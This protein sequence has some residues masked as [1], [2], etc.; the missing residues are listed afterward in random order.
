[1]GAYET[2]MKLKFNVSEVFTSIQGEGSRAGFPSVFIRLQGCELRCKW[3]DTP[4]ALDLKERATMLS[5]EDLLNKIYS[6]GIKFVTITGGEPLNQKAILPF[7]SFLCDKDYTVVLETNGHLDIAEVDRRVVKVMD[8]KCPGSGME[9]FNNY[10]N[11]EA[12]EQKDEIK[13][14][15]L[16]RNDYEWAKAKIKEYDLNKK[17]GTILFS[18]VWGKLEPK[19]L[20]EWILKDALPVRLNLQIHKYIWGP[21][22][23]G[24]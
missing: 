4:Y 5:G 23:R 9:K 21:E 10:R 24:V 13:F 18:P 2:L 6:S 16:D 3:C 1:M 19:Y 7:M 22:T 12:L 20:S 15:I 11:L 17:V 14:V 8:L